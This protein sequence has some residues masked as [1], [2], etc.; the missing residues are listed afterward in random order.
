M[1]FERSTNP[2]SRAI[3]VTGFVVVASAAA[4]ETR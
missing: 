2:A 4:A 3:S 1:K